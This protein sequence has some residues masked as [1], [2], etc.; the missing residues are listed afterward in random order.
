[1]NLST[2]HTKILV[3]GGAGYIGSHTCKALANGGFVPV[4]YDNL[5]TGHRGLVRWGPLVEGDLL[6][7][8]TL[9]RAFADHRPAAVLHFAACAYVGESVEDPA[10]YYRN[11][12]VG[13]LHLLDAARSAGNVPIVFSST[14]AVYGEPTTLPITE[15]APLVPVSPYG[16]TKLMIEHALSDYGAA[17]GLRSICLRYFNAC[18]CD[19]DGEIGESHDP[20]T[21]LVPR[22]ILAAMGRLPELTI[23]G[24]DYPTP[25]GTAI[26]DYVHV[27]DLADAHVAAVRL[28]LGSGENTSL[29][30][31]T[32]A[33]FSVRQIVEAVGRVTDLTVP[34]RVAPRRAG[35]PAVLVADA[36]RARRLLGFSTTH[37]GVE[38]V[39]RTAHAWLAR[40][41]S[42]A[43]AGPSGQSEAGFLR[44]PRDPKSRIA[45]G[46]A[47]AHRRRA[48]G[49]HQ[50]Q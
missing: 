5:S 37:S 41:T 8:D 33:G 11:N 42:A 12:V 22:A 43:T 7:E 38:T 17:Y 15:D 9:K 6:D 47:T 32:G 46:S 14:C 36:S 18:G 21:H 34:C 20:E 45:G 19:P 3:A 49:R 4:V 50:E 13:A 26:R 39:V 31:G 48:S 29:N 2:A 10:K 35:D 28:L 16:R 24:G 1:M 27:C 44:Y 40:G 30:L 23:F 25:D